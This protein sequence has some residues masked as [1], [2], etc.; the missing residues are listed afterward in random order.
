MVGRAVHRTV[1]VGSLNVFPGFGGA[2]GPV[3]P[4][5][6]ERIR[7]LHDGRSGRAS[8]RPNRAGSDPGKRT[9]EVSRGRFSVGS[10][11]GRWWKEFQKGFQRGSLLARGTRCAD[12]VVVVGSPRS[13]PMRLSSSC[14]P[15]VPMS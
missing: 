13:F 14:A 11:S 5:G 4:G 3:R 9:P 8:A 2:A 1:P 12:S 10:G 7:R 6:R 15:T